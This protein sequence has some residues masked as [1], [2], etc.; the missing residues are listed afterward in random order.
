MLLYVLNQAINLPC[1]I[2]NKFIQALIVAPILPP[3]CLQLIQRDFLM[4]TDLHLVS[5]FHTTL[6]LHIHCEGKLQSLNT[7]TIREVLN[8]ALIITQLQ[9]ASI[10]YIILSLLKE[11]KAFF[12]F[13]FQ[14]HNFTRVAKPF[15][16][17]SVILFPPCTLLY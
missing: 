2:S 11:V 9:T 4:C 14:K 6:F 13:I 5:S 10:C 1:N 17:A 15:S 12:N 7:G 8:T 16:E 3:H